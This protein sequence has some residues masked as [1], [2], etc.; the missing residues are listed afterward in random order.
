MNLNI[1][2]VSEFP[3]NTLSNPTPHPLSPKYPHLPV[4]IFTTKSTPLMAIQ[5]LLGSLMA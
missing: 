5:V 2:C 1:G 3:K 4:L